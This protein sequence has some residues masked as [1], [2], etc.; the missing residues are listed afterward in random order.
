MNCKS[1]T[2]FTNKTMLIKKILTLSILITFSC[3]SGSAQ[4]QPSGKSS[5]A[6]KP[7]QKNKKQLI[8]IELFLV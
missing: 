4:R 5:T 8:G 6:S 2:F 3:D 1:M 7:V